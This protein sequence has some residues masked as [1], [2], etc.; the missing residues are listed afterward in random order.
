MSANQLHTNPSVLLET[1]LF[2]FC[3]PTIFMPY[4]G[5]VWPAADSGVF[6][7]GRCLARVSHKRTWP[8]YE[9]PKISVG[10]KGEKVTERTSD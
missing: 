10:W 5:Y 2:A 6:K 1:R 7:T 4:I 9:P 8:E 3:V